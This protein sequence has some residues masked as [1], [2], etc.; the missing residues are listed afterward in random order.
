MAIACMVHEVQA[1]VEVPSFF[2]NGMVLQQQSSVRIWGRSDKSKVTIVT[3]WDKKKYEVQTNADGKWTTQVST[4]AAGGP[5]TIEIGDGDGTVFIQDVL[6]GE[7][8]LASGQ[9]NM[10]MPLKGFKNQPVYKADETV[11]GSENNNIRFFNVEN[12]S[13]GEPLEDTRGHWLPA[14]PQN[15]ANFSATAYFFAKELHE[16]LNVPIAIIQSDW[17]GTPVQAWMGK[18]ALKPFAKR[19]KI[20][21]IGNQ[22][23]E[24][25]GEPTGLY[26]GMIHPLVGYG[27]KGVIWYQGE[28]NRS[29]PSLYAKLFPAMVT[30]W[31][32]DWK[33]GDFPF[34]YVQ[35]APYSS[36]KPDDTN[37]QALRLDRFSPYL[38]DYQLK[39]QADIPNSGMAVLTDAGSASTIHPPDKETVGRRLSYWA[40]NKTYG[41]NDIPYSGPVFKSQKIQG[42]ALVLSFDHAEGLYLKKSTSNNFEI[43]GEDAMFYPAVAVVKGTDIYV[44]S[45]SV[46]KPVA[47][48]YA[49]KSWV[50]GDL[51]NGHNLPASTFKT[52]HWTD[53]DVFKNNN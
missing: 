40:L 25:K 53:S 43:A 20:N 47:V 10:E 48:R 26:N 6:L 11:K 24:K 34:Y 23:Y 5:F 8:W 37:P 17:G 16:K 15:T 41:K 18:D 49:F 31:R 14:S 33:I 46:N 2:S 45:P 30:Q 42:N 36:L 21:E 44:S 9:S 27:I 28:A 32:Q 52:D 38:R 51:F 35:I 39:A 29:A 4:V 1:K 19:T 7:V 12:K 22:A 50:E 13:W 3:S